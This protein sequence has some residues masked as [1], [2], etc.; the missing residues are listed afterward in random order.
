MSFILDI[1][2][3]VT[4]ALCVYSGIRKGAVRVIITIAGYILAFIIATFVSGAFSEPIYENAVKT[5]VMSALET[6]ASEIADEYLSTE[7]F[8]EMLYEN[9]ITLTDEQLASVIENGDEFEKIL[10]NEKLRDTVNKTFTAY[11]EKLTEAF[12][13]IVPDEI[14][15]EAELYIENAGIKNKLFSDDKNFIVEIVETEI[16]R[17]VIIGTIKAI[18]FSLSF[19]I[20]MAVVSVVSR[21]S[22]VVKKIPIVNSANG[23]LGGILGFCR[24]ILFIMVLSV[25]VSVFIKLTSGTNTLINR[26]VISRTWLFDSLYNGTFFILSLIL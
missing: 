10:S 8:G 15:E 13:G 25:G 19:I 22:N 5:Y 24:G 11:C 26:D 6:K 1:T 3:I 9:G 21:M 16:V 18:L 12:S 4:I 7:K 2:V 20:V 14:I 17:P 23:F